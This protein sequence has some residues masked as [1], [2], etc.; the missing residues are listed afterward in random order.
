MS[1]RVENVLEFEN[2]KILFKNFS[3]KEKK[4]NREGDRNFTVIIP[5]EEMAIRLK[6]DGWNV[7]QLRSRDEDEPGDYA[8]RV[9]VSYKGR[10][11]RVVLIAHGKQTVL[12]EQSINVMDY[13]DIERVDLVVNPYNW[14]ANGKVGVKAY[15]RSMY[16]TLAEDKFAAKYADMEFSDDVP[17]Y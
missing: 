15:L 10:P 6:N 14:E 16:V 9:T 11:P 2:A 4:F 7:R 12:D 8:M 1:Y 5:D 3:G 13:A 17:L